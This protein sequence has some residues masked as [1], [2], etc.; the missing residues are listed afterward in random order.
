MARRKAKLGYVY[1][2]QSQSKES[3]YKYGCTTLR[4]GIRC[5]KL[6]SERKGM[7]FK[8]ISSYKSFDIFND[9]NTIKWHLLP[10]GFGALG[11]MFEISFGDDPSFVE[12]PTKDKLIERF[13]LVGGVLEAA[14][15]N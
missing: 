1:L 15:D 4:P 2:V 14:S 8:V 9:E 3:I 7:D 5:K 12:I 13:L 10:S 11:E 6:N